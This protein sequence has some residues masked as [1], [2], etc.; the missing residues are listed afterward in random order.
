[1]PID[2][3]FDLFGPVRDAVGRKTVERTFDAPVTVGDALV[4]LG[5]SHP[6]L[7][8]HLG[9]DENLGAGLTITVD[10]DNVSLRDG[11]DTELS[12]GD[13]VRIAPPVVGG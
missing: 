12:D 1:V 10:G 8:D 4:A 13:V 3:Q 9:S 11:L 5:E 7:A 2:V 6:S